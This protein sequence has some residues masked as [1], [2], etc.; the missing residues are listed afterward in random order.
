MHSLTGLCGSHVLTCPALMQAGLAAQQ[1]RFHWDKRRRQYVQLQPNEH[2]QAGKRKRT[3][4]GKQRAKD[5]GKPTGIYNKWVRSSKLRVPAAGEL[6]EG[7]GGAD[8]AHL[9]DRYASG[10]HPVFFVWN[11]SNK[12]ARRSTGPGW[13]HRTFPS[14]CRASVMVPSIW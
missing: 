3:E 2:V 6:M 11:G 4:S 1:R 7:A 12:A 13:C 10:M 14:A 5:G 9:A 8:T